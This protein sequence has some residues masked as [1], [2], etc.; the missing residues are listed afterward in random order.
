MLG[1][2][3]TLVQILTTLSRLVIAFPLND[4]APVTTKAMPSIGNIHN[5]IGKA[6]NDMAVARGLIRNVDKRDHRLRKG[7]VR[8]KRMSVRLHFTCHYSGQ[9]Y[10]DFHWTI[11]YDSIAGKVFHIPGHNIGGFANQKNDDEVYP[12]PFSASWHSYINSGHSVDNYCCAHNFSAWFGGLAEVG[13]VTAQFIDHDPAGERNPTIFEVCS[14]QAFGSSACSTRVVGGQCH[15]RRA[16]ISSLGR[17]M[18][19]DT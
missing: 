16:D 5:K 14:E 15:F 9:L 6:S 2:R 17:S 1:L 3:M 13:G 7:I 12:V 4:A 11:M 8:I 19:H 10:Q 18:L